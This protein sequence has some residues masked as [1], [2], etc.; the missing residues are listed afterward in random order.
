MNRKN[1]SN[2]TVLFLL[3]VMLL[4]SAC[5]FQK[6][7]NRLEAILKEGVLVVGTS[8][9]YPPFE[10]L[11]ESKNLTGFDMDFIEEVSKRMGVRL[12]I[13]N[14]PF[15]DLIP[16]VQDRSID[17]AVAAFNRTDER[18]GVVD[19]SD[20][21]LRLE[22]AFLA[23]ENFSGEISEPEDTAQFKIGA[24]SESPADDWITTDLVEAGS[25]P[26]SDFVRYDRIDQAVS[27]LKNGK[28]DLLMIDFIPA[29][30]LINEI[31]GLKIVFHDD[32]SRSSSRIVL[33]QGA[34]ALAT[35]INKFI[36]EMYDDGFIEEL[37]QKY[38]S[39]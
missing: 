15:D 28:I 22:D 20:A 17:I 16:A 8:A 24:L 4:S 11:D 1:L 13:V 35:A 18:D 36:A 32:V 31:E 29:Q 23:T 34:R 2:R 6:P 38:F 37:T 26:E 12:E 39:Q 19:F 5:T 10:Y 33:P 30:K 9:D 25:M 7:A 3:V 27:D 14:M 21:Y